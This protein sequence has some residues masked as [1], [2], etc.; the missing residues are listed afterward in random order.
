MIDER[1]R[2]K[3]MVE[4][5]RLLNA[6]DVDGLLGLYADEVTFEDPV[7]ADQRSGRDALRA[8]FEEFVRA[9]VRETLGDPV[10]GQ[11]GKHVLAPASAVM[12]YLP[13]GPGF[14]ERGWITAPD[15][16]TGKRI[17]WNYVL[18]L[19]TGKGGAITE[20]KALWG[21]SDLAV[22]D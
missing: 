21:R 16:P 4:H 20:L 12:D 5:S 15:D 14:A 2:K 7:G 1:S 10:A 8:H 13:K 19:R 3:L 11:D 18:M 9:G 22:T 17:T 6:A